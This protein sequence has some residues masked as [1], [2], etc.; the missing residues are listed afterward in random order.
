MNIRFS[1]SGWILGRGVDE[2]GSFM[3]SGKPQFDILGGSWK[4]N[5]TYTGIDKELAIWLCETGEEFD[6]WGDNVQIDEELFGTSRSHVSHIAYWSDFYCSNTTTLYSRDIVHASYLSTARSLHISSLVGFFGI[7]EP[8]SN[9]QHF[10]LN[11]GGVFS[12]IPL[13]S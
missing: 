12:A 1:C 5:K 7:W 2:I 8:K 10:E 6:D 3:I 4:L 13:F 11:R 9:E